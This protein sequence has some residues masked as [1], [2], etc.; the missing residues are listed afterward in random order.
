MA[1]DVA[2][3]EDL[4]P[5]GFVQSASPRSCTKKHHVSLFTR[6]LRDTEVNGFM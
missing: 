3:V 1:Q 4:V 2:G 6:V 5:W